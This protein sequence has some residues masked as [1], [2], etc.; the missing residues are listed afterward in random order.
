MRPNSALQYEW[1][2]GQVPWDDGGDIDVFFK[3]ER[4]TGT[5]VRERLNQAVE[6][7]VQFFQ[8]RGYQTQARQTSAGSALHS[9]PLPSHQ[10]HALNPFTMPELTAAVAAFGQPL[11][12]RFGLDEHQAAIFASVVEHIPADRRR[13]DWLLAHATF[14]APAQMRITVSNP[15]NGEEEVINLI[16]MMPAD[17]NDQGRPIATIA[18]D[19][20][21]A[22]C[23]V[24]IAAV[25]GQTNGVLA[26]EGSSEA[27]ARAGMRRMRLTEFSFEPILPLD[28]SH[29]DWSDAGKI[30]RTALELA[31]QR[32]MC[33]IAKYILRGYEWA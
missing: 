5:E 10:A 32:Q 26:F 7:T 25:A 20:D 30:R 13:R 2:L 18:D 11:L 19:F 15:M 4:S 17:A 6:A 29:G 24:S 14:D 28:Y 23:G 33:R 3:C 27:L 1:R 16:G 9:L 12:N 31:V 21:L 8:S 22:Q